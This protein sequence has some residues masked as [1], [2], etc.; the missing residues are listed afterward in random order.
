M[1]KAYEIQTID[2][3][4]KIP[5]ERFD[6]FYEEFKAFIEMTRATVNLIDICAEATGVKAPTQALK[7]VWKDD[8]KKNIDIVLDVQK[9]S[10]K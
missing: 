4:L 9:E 6:T 8:G 2:D 10:K 5:E 3:M 7:M 1:S